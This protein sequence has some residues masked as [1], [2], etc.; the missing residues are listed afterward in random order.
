VLKL[1]A[2]CGKP[3]PHGYA[4]CSECKALRYRGSSAQRGYGAEWQKL[5]RRFLAEHPVCRLCNEPATDVDHIISK[6]KGGT[7][8]WENLQPMCR[9]HHSIKTAS[10]DGGFGN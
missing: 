6:R 9:R 4:Y 7:D 2:N 5:R 10:E 8:D 3:I 1:C